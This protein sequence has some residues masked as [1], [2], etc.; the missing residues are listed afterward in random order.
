MRLAIEYGDGHVEVE[1]PDDTTVISADD[2][3]GHAHREPAPLADP[4]AATREALANPLGT[5]PIG[6]LVARGSPVTIAFPDRVKGGAHATAH[7]KVV[8][9]LL[10]DELSAAGVRPPG[11][12]LVCAIGLHRKNR[13]EEFLGYLGQ[14]GARPRAGGEHRQP[15]RRGPR[16]DGRP[17]ALVARRPGAGEQGRRGVRPVDHDRPHGGQPVRRL[18]RWLQD[19]GHRTDLVALDRLAPRAAVALPRRLRAGLRSQP[20]PRPAHRHRGGAWRR[21]CPAV[22]QRRR[23]ARLAVHASSGSRA[24]RIPTSSRP[25]GRWP[26][27]APTC[28]SP[29]SPRTCCWSGS[30]AR[31]TTGRGWAPTRS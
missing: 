19:A 3:A 23:G 18:Q 25:P 1:L 7:R 10:L 2:A 22:L 4:V 12:R 26:A 11:L 5:G 15:R 20:V 31:S 16:R 17:G 9:P 6:D 28:R 14:R 13:R 30:R 8:L 24:G 29:A 27:S 21:G